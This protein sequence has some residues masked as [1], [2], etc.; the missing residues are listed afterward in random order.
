ML[1]YLKYFNKIYFVKVIELLQKSPLQCVGTSDYICRNI[2]NQIYS[3]ISIMN[4]KN[5]T[6]VI[7]HCLQILYLPTRLQ[8]I[9]KNPRKGSTTNTAGGLH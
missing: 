3:L 9:C 7:C 8:I 5:I 6:K 4:Y 1:N 2:V